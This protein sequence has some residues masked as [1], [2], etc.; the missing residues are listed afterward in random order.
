MFICLAILGKKTKRL[1]LTRKRK[2]SLSTPAGYTST[3]TPHLLCTCWAFLQIT[4]MAG[5]LQPNRFWFLSMNIVCCVL[6]NEQFTCHTAYACAQTQ[7][8]NLTGWKWGFERVFHK[9]ILS[10]PCLW[11][12]FHPLIPIPSSSEALKVSL[13]SCIGPR[14]RVFF[15]QNFAKKQPKKIGSNLPTGIV[16]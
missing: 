2:V 3:F 9:V 12:S 11:S 7:I 16:F 8:D 4:D 10:S 1:N 15:W 14:T 6:S 5:L 13:W